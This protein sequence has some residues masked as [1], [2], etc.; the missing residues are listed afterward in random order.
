VV[1]DLWHEWLIGLEDGGMERRTTVEQ[2][3]EQRNF[4]TTIPTLAASIAG[5][6]K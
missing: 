4:E 6:N 2:E 5:G 3:Q 1:R